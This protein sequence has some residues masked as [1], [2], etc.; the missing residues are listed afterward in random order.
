[1]KVPESCNPYQCSKVVREV[2]FAKVFW[3]LWSRPCLSQVHISLLWLID[4]TVLEHMH[5]IE[6]KQIT[7]L[8][9]FQKKK[10]NKKI[11]KQKK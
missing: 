11:S 2:W 4:P 3:R 5:I 10:I 6:L 7:T 1:M 9:L 8:F